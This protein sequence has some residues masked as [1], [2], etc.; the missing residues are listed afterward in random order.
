MKTLIMAASI[1]LS[2]QAYAQEQGNVEL[3]ET[4]NLSYKGKPILAK[5]KI[6][7]TPAETLFE[8]LRTDPRGVQNLAD[9]SSNII[10][11][12]E[13]YRCL[14]KAGEE[15]YCEIHIQNVERGQIIKH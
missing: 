4:T 5:L 9:G 10:R 13:N 15:V 2:I 7:G 12:G 1:L 8:Q 3:V 11:V 6:T 14:K